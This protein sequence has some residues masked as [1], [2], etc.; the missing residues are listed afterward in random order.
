MHRP[1]PTISEF[2]HSIPQDR[3]IILLNHTPLNSE[4]DAAG[5][6]GADLVLSGHTHAG[7]IWPFSLLTGMVYKYQWG[8]FKLAKGYIFTSCGI[9]YWGPP[10]RL[11]APPEIGLIQFVEDN[12]LVN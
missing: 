9:G 8:L 7:Q 12:A 6:A 11:G 1:R 10:M 3:T 2:L 4:V 5:E